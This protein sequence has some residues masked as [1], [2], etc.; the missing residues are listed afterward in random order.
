MVEHHIQIER[1]PPKVCVNPRSNTE[2]RYRALYNQ[3]EIG[4]SRVPECDAAR[5]L[6]DQKLA[7]RDDVLVVYRGSTPCLRGSLGWFADHTIRENDVYNNG[8]PSLVKWKPFVQFS[9]K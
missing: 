1:V 3:Q 4:V 6:L 7:N 8:T 2:T 5:W 9:D